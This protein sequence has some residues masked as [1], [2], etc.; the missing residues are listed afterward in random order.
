VTMM[1]P[2]RIMDPPGEGRLAYVDM[3]WQTRRDVAKPRPTEQNRSEEG[4][5]A[6]ALAL[7]HM[8][9][10]LD[11]DPT[12]EMNSW[13][14]RPWEGRS[15][16]LCLPQHSHTAWIAHAP[17]LH[18]HPCPCL[19]MPSCRGS[20]GEAMVNS[21]SMDQTYEVRPKCRY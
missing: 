13:T 15:C 7:K 10:E 4:Q 6:A 5:K 1:D 8:Q 3:L 17:R 20:G 11:T 21:L 9:G 19:V 2:P 18:H 14:A 12:R 16:L